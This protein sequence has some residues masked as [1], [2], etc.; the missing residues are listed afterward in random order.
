VS[1]KGFSCAAHCLRPAQA[2]AANAGVMTSNSDDANLNYLEA[3]PNTNPLYVDLGCKGREDFVIADTHTKITRFI[4]PRRAFKYSIAPGTTTVYKV[5]MV[6][7][8]S[9]TNF[10]T[11]NNND[12]GPSSQELYLHM[13]KNF[14][15]G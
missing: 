4:D 1:L 2:T 11:V 15:V 3:Q 9:Y 7:L 10:S 13:N 6:H 14:A 5:Y 12:L 8:N